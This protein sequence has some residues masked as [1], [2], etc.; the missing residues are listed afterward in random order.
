M[1]TFNS[2]CKGAE[3]CSLALG[4]AS[5]LPEDRVRSS[6][7]SRPLT[8]GDTSRLQE[9]RVRRSGP[10][11]CLNKPTT[12]SLQYIKQ[13][14]ESS[15]I[16]TRLVNLH[17]QRK[18][19][20]SGISRAVSPAFHTPLLPVLSSKRVFLPDYFIPDE[21]DIIVARDVKKRHYNGPNNSVPFEILLHKVL[22]DFI[23]ASP[24]RR[25]KLIDDILRALT[26]CGAR[27]VG[28]SEDFGLWHIVDYKEAREFTTSELTLAA[29][30][31]LTSLKCYQENEK[32]RQVRALSVDRAG[33]S[34]DKLIKVRAL[35]VKFKRPKKLS[36]R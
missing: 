2:E 30:E 15:S 6:G 18:V 23:R 14:V 35:Q 36:A 24:K 4:D 9:D 16:P 1:E 29:R 17:A 28:K 12:P 31:I 19:S 13:M 8:V 27:F 10:F 33:N 21:D 11:Y 7:C 20:F 26:K 32:K 25:G 3:G 22:P 34:K 5:L